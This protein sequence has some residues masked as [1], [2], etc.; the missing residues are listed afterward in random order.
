M[1]FHSPA[2]NS[3]NLPAAC[4]KLPV[5]KSHECQSCYLLNLKT[6]DTC[7]VEEMNQ[8]SLF[9]SFLKTVSMKRFFLFVLL[10]SGFS[11]AAQKGFDMELTGSG[12]ISNIWGDWMVVSP[13]SSN[14]ASQQLAPM[15]GKSTFGYEAGLSA[16]YH[17]G[18]HTG[19]RLGC[20][21]SSLGQDYNTL[22]I[23]EKS[24]YGF[25]VL[26]GNYTVD[27]SLTLSYLKLP[28]TF[29]W[30]SNPTK[31]I[32]CT[33]YAGVYFGILL[34]F[35][36]NMSAQNNYTIYYPSYTA[37]Y[38]DSE[39]RT[40][41]GTNVKDTYVQSGGY[42]QSNPCTLSGPPY[43][44]FDFGFVGGAGI[45]VRINDRF[46]IPVMV[47]G[48]TG[49]IDIR[50]MGTTLTDGSGHTYA[51]FSDAGSNTSTHVNTFLGFNLGL[52]MKLHKTESPQNSQAGLPQIQ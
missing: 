6:P 39:T 28:L 36:E 38:Q 48:Q 50:N 49:V 44:S 45:Q 26:V 3:Q 42:T 17:F 14:N 19:I 16:G 20:S 25:I 46:S 1:I 41:T 30:N 13:Q 32:I 21:Y 9:P 12:G 8:I 43:Q 51:Y 34:N 4:L 15:Q 24:Y 27:R 5:T 7:S 2:L 22:N 11:G 18:P 52:R 35:I 23:P 29:E 40:T 47:T 37:N 10:V 31:R 33:A